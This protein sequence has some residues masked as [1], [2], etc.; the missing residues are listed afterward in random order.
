MPF[1]AVKLQPV[2]TTT[3]VQSATSSKYVFFPIED[4]VEAFSF[5]PYARE[6]MFASDQGMFIDGRPTVEICRLM[7]VDGNLALSSPAH[8]KIIAHLRYEYALNLLQR[9]GSTLSRVGLDFK[10]TAHQ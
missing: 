8:V 2:K 1:T 5:E 4:N 6:E 9:L 3:A 7:G 10:T